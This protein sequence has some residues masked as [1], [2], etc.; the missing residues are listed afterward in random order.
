MIFNL[1][2][3]IFCI[4]LMFIQL[5]FSKKKMNKSAAL[6][7]LNVAFCI[8][9]IIS[10]L[11]ITC[12]KS[13]IQNYQYIILSVPAGY[14]TYIISLFIVGTKINKISLLPFKCFQYGRKPAKAARFQIFKTLLTSIYEEFLFRGSIQ[15]T[16]LLF[17]GE[18]FIPIL[19]TIII[20]TVMH[21]EKQKAIVQ[22]IDLATFSLALGVLFY[23]TNCIWLVVVIHVL[24][25]S[26]L[27]CFLHTS[28]IERMQKISIMKK[29]MVVNIERTKR[30]GIKKN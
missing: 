2:L 9:Y 21:C 25:N 1:G 3:M 19:I 30:A 6:N 22:I 8:F 16:L 5:F 28:G 11:Y 20:F 17:T 29:R 26:L 27:I 14:L 23:L 18:S 15:T 4:C 10:T 13:I 12:F 7:R 24:R